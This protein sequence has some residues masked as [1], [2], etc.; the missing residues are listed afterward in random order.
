MYIDQM[1]P[2]LSYL[3][4][5][6]WPSDAEWQVNEIENALCIVSYH[7]GDLK[8]DYCLYELYDGWLGLTRISFMRLLT[9]DVHVSVHPD[10]EYL[11]RVGVSENEARDAI[12]H[13]PGI[14]SFL[15]QSVKDAYGI[16]PR[17]LWR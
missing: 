10:L 17:K 7:S 13:S 6:H 9:I 16:V 2:E 5:S 11:L 12:V 8:V 1:S 15:T 3:L 4:S 14:S